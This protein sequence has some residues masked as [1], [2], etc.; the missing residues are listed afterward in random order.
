MLSGMTSQQLTEWM[1]FFRLEPWG[2]Q[3][4][5]LRAG[6][7]GALVVNSNPWRGKG[8]QP[9]K[10]EELFPT[11]APEAEAGGLEVQD[12]EDMK[13]AARQFAAAWGPG[14]AGGAGGMVG[15]G[16]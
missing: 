1:E 4:S 15:I 13:R 16:K 10:P 3:R 5:D 8:A 2:P 14:A 7:L 9:L 12:V 11:L 6:I